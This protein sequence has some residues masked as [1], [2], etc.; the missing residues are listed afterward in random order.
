M[1]ARAISLSFFESSSS[2]S[3]G[4]KWGKRCVAPPPPRS[5]WRRP[6][7]SLSRRQTPAPALLPSFLIFC[8]VAAFIPGDQEGRTLTETETDQARSSPAPRS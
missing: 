8:L 3:S 7:K 6:I 2:S 4:N 1:H 5:V